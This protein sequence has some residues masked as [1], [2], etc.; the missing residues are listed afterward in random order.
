MP[1]PNGA[2]RPVAL[3]SAQEIA[4]ELGAVQVGAREMG[5]DPF[6]IARVRR[7]A[8]ILARLEQALGAGR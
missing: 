5:R 7:L 3:Q 1:G 2:R 4:D 8:E 6:L